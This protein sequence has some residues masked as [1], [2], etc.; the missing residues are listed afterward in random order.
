MPVNYQALVRYRVINRRLREFQRS[1]IGELKQAC[2]DALSIKDMGDRTIEGDIHEMR[3]N[4]LLGYN[5]PIA[6]D[7]FRAAY[8]YSDP[9]FS[10]E[11]IPLSNDEINSMLFAARLLEQYS[12]IGIFSQFADS[13]R[14][15][16]EAVS[17]FREFHEEPYANAIE[18]E[19]AVYC[20]G[21]EHLS[22]LIKAI[23]AMKAVRLT[24]RSF[25]S[26]KSTENLIH[27]YLLKEY[28]N[29]WYLVGFNVRYNA[30]RTYCL[31]R[32]E[33]LE[34]D[35]R[36]NFLKPDFDAKEYYR[37]VI[38]I[39]VLNGKPQEIEIS[40]SDLQTQ[41]ITTQPLHSSQRKLR[42]ENGMHVFGFRLI[43]NFEFMSYIMGL[44]REAVIL[45][46]QS[47]RVKMKKA[48]QAAAENY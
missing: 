6:Y 15:I 16:A 43:P 48:L 27:P 32:F 41:Y 19:N 46:P 11:N 1:T 20:G 29:R 18:F 3:H 31:D 38:G 45:K 8:Y 17:V 12:N 4:K 28:R 47:L 44:G 37:N 39:S 35:E 26:E 42:L 10:I 14:K 24:Y 30:V 33:D 34:T 5:A 22:Q 25:T 9:G 2:M 13:A 7:R 21:T 40:F 36:V 23:I